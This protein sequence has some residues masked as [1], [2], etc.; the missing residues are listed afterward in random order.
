MHQYM[1]KEEII[2]SLKVQANVDPHLA[3]LV[4]SKLH[5]QN[6]SFFR[7]YNLRLQLKEN[8]DTFNALVRFDVNLWSRERSNPD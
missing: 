5:D 2:A 1:S 3:S 6:P 7:V 8:I 4:W